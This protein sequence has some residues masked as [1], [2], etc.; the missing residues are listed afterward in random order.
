MEERDNVER[1][2]SGIGLGKGS[3]RKM[4]AVTS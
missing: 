1:V 4:T 2:G 3:W